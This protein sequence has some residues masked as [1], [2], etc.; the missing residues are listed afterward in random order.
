MG[1]YHGSQ[2]KGYVRMDKNAEALHSSYANLKGALFYNVEG[3]C[4]T[5]KCPPYTE[6]AELACVVCSNST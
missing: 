2:D 1:E 6:G 5:M 3:R 4:C